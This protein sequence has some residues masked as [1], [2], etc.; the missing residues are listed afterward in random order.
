MNKSKAQIN[1]P[2]PPKLLLGLEIIG[3]SNSSVSFRIMII[4]HSILN[5]ISTQYHFHV[6]NK[7]YN[8]KRY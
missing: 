5:I 8:L 1:P 7:L 6:L 3:I 4:T 2:P